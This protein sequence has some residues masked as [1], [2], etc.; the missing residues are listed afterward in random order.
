MRMEATPSNA[1]TSEANYGRPGSGALV[2][3]TIFG[4]LTYSA[5]AACRRAEKLH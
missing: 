4:E 2:A 3:A 1:L 5:A